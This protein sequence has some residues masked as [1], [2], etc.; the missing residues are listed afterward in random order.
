MR[1]GRATTFAC[2]RMLNIREDYN[3]ILKEQFLTLNFLDLSEI[4][5]IFI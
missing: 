4:N 1:E 3:I 5:I 2:R